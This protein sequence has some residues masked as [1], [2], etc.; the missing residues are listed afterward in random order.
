M[1][2]PT[3]KIFQVLNILAKAYL[4]LKQLLTSDYNLFLKLKYYKTPKW[5]NETQSSCFFP[6]TDNLDIYPF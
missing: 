3:Y 5:F 4:K 1:K 6:G 2:N